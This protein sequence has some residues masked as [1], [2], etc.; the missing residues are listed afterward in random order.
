MRFAR[1]ASLTGQD[2]LWEPQG[3]AQFGRAP[4]WGT[5]GRWFKS[6]YSDDNE[7]SSGATERLPFGPW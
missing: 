1:T 2:G 5:G 6:G 7:W 3:I 4:V